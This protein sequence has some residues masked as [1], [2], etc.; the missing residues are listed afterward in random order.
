[1]E[2]RVF[3][4]LKNANCGIS[5]GQ[6]EDGKK[7][8]K[9]GGLMMGRR[10]KGQWLCVSNEGQSITNK[11]YFISHQCLELFPTVYLKLKKLLL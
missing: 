9:V 8:K 5:F 10:H 4:C 2:F 11:N 7:K 3:A 6:E 1:M